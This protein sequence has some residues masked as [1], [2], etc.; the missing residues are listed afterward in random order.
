MFWFWLKTGQFVFK[1]FPSS[2]CWHHE[3]KTS[4]NH[5]VTWQSVQKYCFHFINITV[6]WTFSINVFRRSNSPDFSWAVCV[7]FECHQL[8]LTSSAP[9]A[10]CPPVCFQRA[11]SQYLGSRCCRATPASAAR[12]PSLASPRRRKRCRSSKPHI[13]KASAPWTSPA[14]PSP[15]ALWVHTHTNEWIAKRATCLRPGWVVSAELIRDR[16]H[17]GGLLPTVSSFSPHIKALSR[18]SQSLIISFWSLRVLQLI[19]WAAGRVSTALMLWDPCC[20]LVDV[21][22]CVLS[23]LRLFFFFCITLAQ[24]SLEEQRMR[25]EWA[26][27][28]QRRKKIQPQGEKSGR[29]KK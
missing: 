17:D 25:N 14:S 29:E 4:P 18:I 2:C 12:C 11:A 23:Q 20:Y 9:L 28:S 16:A 27:E 5:K 26:W 21:C 13:M 15:S 24:L 19:C 6:P 22:F 8:Q 3:P 7:L 1:Q 10:F